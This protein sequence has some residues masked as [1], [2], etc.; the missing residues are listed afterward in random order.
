VLV[1]G[2]VATL[3]VIFACMLPAFYAL[4]SNPPGRAQ[5]IPQYVLVCSLAVLGCLAGTLAPSTS[6]RGF[7]KGVRDAPINPLLSGAAAV[8]LVVLLALGPLLT[9]AR[10]LQQLATARAYAAA[11]DQ[12]DA[13]VRAERSRGV[14]DVTVARLASTGNVQNLEF[15]G[16][17]R[18]DW[19]NDCVARYYDLSSIAAD[20]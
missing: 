17:N 18:R 3:L 11:W 8:G 4:G 12:L 16:T 1:A 19:F 6:G 14:R 20:A 9:A 15:V 5:V 2:V 10:D 7:I 13:G